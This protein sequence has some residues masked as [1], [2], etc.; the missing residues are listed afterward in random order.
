[1]WSREEGIDRSPTTLLHAEPG[2]NTFPQTFRTR[3]Y[4]WSVAAMRE[5]QWG[6]SM[7]EVVNDVNN[8][9]RAIYEGLCDAYG[10]PML[11]TFTD[12][13]RNPRLRSPEYQLEAHLDHCP[14]LEV[15]NYIGAVFQV[16]ERIIEA[17]GGADP[18]EEPR[19]LGAELNRIFEEEGIGYRWT[20]GR[21]VRYD[22][23]VTHTEAMVPALVALASGRFGTAASE[24]DAAVAAFGRGGWRDTITNA[25]AALESVLKILTGEKGT[26]GQ[27][28]KAA[29]DR[30]PRLIP[31]YLGTGAK[32]FG[33]MMDGINAARS[34]QGAHGLGGRESEADE[35]LARLILTWTAALITFLAD[36]QPT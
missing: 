12:A 13:K 31:N 3:V 1:M 30:E 16:S 32:Q 19:R 27:L 11:V 28:I 25:N 24:F 33:D 15:M 18:V 9:L 14:D 4:R 6:T 21:I 2:K 26:A 5:L 22:G 36:D 34:Q 17:G 7:G 23:E 10:R 35:R 8:S 20:E 29:V